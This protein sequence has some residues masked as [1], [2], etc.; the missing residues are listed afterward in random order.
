MCPPTPSSL[1]QR[2]RRRDLARRLPARGDSHRVTVSVAVR[3]SPPVAALIFTAVLTVTAFVVIGNVTVVAPTDAVTVALVGVATPLRLL[4]SA[5][6]IGSG[7]AGHSSVAV[8]VA[9]VPP[10]TDVGVSTSEANRIG[11][12]VSE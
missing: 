5:M 6:M 7:P 10:R 2:P 9:P 3:V 4:L 1:D 8:P 11:R 12:N